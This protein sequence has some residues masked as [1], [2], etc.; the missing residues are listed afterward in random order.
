M[1]SINIESIQIH[2]N[3]KEKELTF[4]ATM[5]PPLLNTTPLH[6]LY[7]SARQYQR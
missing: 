2:T 1:N 5:F 4:D 3:L 7:R 6:Q